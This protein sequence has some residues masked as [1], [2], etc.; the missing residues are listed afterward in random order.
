MQ[1]TLAER[2]I[3]IK[4]IDARKVSLQDLKKL[5][6]KCG[7][8]ISASFDTNQYGGHIGQATV[9]YSRASS[10]A[11][12]IKSYDRAQIDGKPIRVMYALAQTIQLP[13]GVQ[14][15]QATPPPRRAIPSPP[16]KR[17]T[18]NRIQKH[19]PGRTLDMRRGRGGH[20]QQRGGK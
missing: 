1:G 11:R 10:A 15:T 12:A 8:L 14:V 13:S 2:K 6:G 19:R 3:K 5:F 20:S 18:V 7:P 4:Q 17:H 16:Q 9:I